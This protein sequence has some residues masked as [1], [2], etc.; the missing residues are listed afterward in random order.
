MKER[1]HERFPIDYV[2]IILTKNPIVLEKE[3]QVPGV[4]MIS[5]SSRVGRL[6]K[7]LKCQFAVSK[8][9]Q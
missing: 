8:H 2:F 1:V 4:L 3:L 5:K 9:S 7:E 6:G